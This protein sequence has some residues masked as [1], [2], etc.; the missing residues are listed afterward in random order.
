MKA[1]TWLKGLLRNEGGNVLVVGAATMPLLI[2]AA[3]FGVDTMQLTVWKRQLQRAADSSAIAGA[4]AWSQG[5]NIHDA[6]H[7]DL[8][9]NRFPTLSEEEDI[10]QGA[11]GDFDRTVR[12]RL[13][14]TREL[15]FMSLFTGK[16]AAI[17]ADARAALDEDGTF[18][19]I[20]LYADQG[21][22]IRVHGNAE[23][24]LGCGMK[25]NATG[26]NTVIT[27]GAKAF[28][29]ASPIGSRGGLDG[30]SNNFMDPTTLQP[31]SAMQQD[32]LAYLEDPAVPSNCSSAIL[33]PDNM[34]TVKG[35]YCFAAMNIPS[36]TVATIP[37]GSTITINGGDVTV[38]GTLNGT[39]V[40][41]IMTGADGDAGTVTVNAKAVLNL[42]APEDGTYSG[43]L[44]YRDR[45]A[46]F[47]TIT[48]NGGATSK[49]SGALYFPT[50]DLKFNG[51]AQMDVKCLQMVGRIL[52]FGGTAG[53]TN[54]CPDTKA[55]QAFKQTVVRLV[56]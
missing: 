38:H 32:P 23:V 56:S 18:C 46:D 15:P 1:A 22:G 28:I 19:M 12:V 26:D 36:N 13:N 53:V 9:K 29:K 11:W 10:D 6:V 8:D 3:A 49:I 17:I 20:S 40:A 41:V 37:A 35:D 51:H 25:T 7:D 44:F 33:T 31:F 4:Y 39:N 27:N 34:P 48:I 55:A 47:T 14:A 21:Y 45:R 24:S 43:V 16:P 50:A 54:E 2:G 52:D 42:T 30:T 5:V